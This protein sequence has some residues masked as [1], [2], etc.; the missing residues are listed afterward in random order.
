MD[1]FDAWCI[2][3]GVYRDSAGKWQVAEDE[4]EDNMDLETCPQCEERAYDGRLCHL[5]G[6]KNI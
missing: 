5:C 4:E 3:N 1:E 6:A 2:R